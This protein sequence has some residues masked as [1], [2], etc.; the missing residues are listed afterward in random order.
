MSNIQMQQTLRMKNNIVFTSVLMVLMMISCRKDEFNGIVEIPE[1]NFPQTVVFE[2]SLSAYNV[3]QGLASDLVPASDFELLELSSSLFTD[4]AHKQRLVKLPPG[5]QMSR[6]DD[7]SLS[8]PN[9][10]ILTKTF[11][12]YTDERDFSLGKT[13]IETRLIIKESDI[14][15]AATYRWN[16]AQT[17]ATLELNG[18]NTQVTWINSTGSNL[19]TLYKIPT[20][21]ECKTCHQSNSSMTPLGPTILNLNRTVERNGETVNQLSHLQEIGILTYFSAEQA[22][23]MVDFNDLGSPIEERGRAYLAMNCAHCHNPT[24]WNVPADRDFDF[25]FAT[26]L[27]GSGVEPGRFKIIENMANQKMPFIG[28][29]L[30]DEEGLALILEYIQSLE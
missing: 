20:E 15:N 29:T 17:A 7:N 14:W 5:T 2:D 11:F 24:A 13:I 9:G 22:P 12:Y 23:R 26:S 25:R 21:N 19:S 3:F 28:T 1:F 10:T 30:L 16:E 6:L 8:Y 27:E 4:Y 18:F